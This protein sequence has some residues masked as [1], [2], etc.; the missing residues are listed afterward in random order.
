MSTV[1]TIGEQRVVLHNVRWSTYLA[2]LEDTE[3]CRGRMIYDQGVL[4]IMS[5]LSSHENIGCLIGRMIE[6]YTEVM[7]IEIV[8]IASTT[9]KREALQR[10]FEADEAY[11]IKHAD[12][13]RGRNIIDFAID[14]P[15]DLV[16]EVDISRSS[17][18]KLPIFAAFGV[19]EVWRYLGDTFQ[20]L[21]LSGI[22]YSPADCSGVLP[23]FPLKEV[24][25][26]LGQRNTSGE[27]ELIRAF[28]ASLSKNN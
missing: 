9:V 23:G 20:A 27:T 16:V 3:P 7:G 10:G 11:Y 12:L 6:T 22:E 5:P 17:I 26:L 4:E 13:V 15:P 28:R 24:P 1:S 21:V 19:P 25:R 8:S 14:P 18:A 2:L